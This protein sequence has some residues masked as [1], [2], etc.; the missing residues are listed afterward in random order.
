MTRSA[1]GR[2]GLS[3]VGLQR[4]ADSAREGT[5]AKAGRSTWGI[6]VVDVKVNKQRGGGQAGIHMAQLLSMSRMNRWL[7]Y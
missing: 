4:S 1:H 7:G 6:V 3:D 5:K 2:S